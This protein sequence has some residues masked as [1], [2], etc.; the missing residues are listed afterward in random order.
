M[1]GQP[2]SNP[3]LPTG[4]EPLRKASRPLHPD[5]ARARARPDTPMDFLH[6][7]QR[8]VGSSLD[9]DRALESSAGD[10]VPPESAE[11]PRAIMP[12]EME[13]VA[14]V[15]TKG[16]P[17]TPSPPF[18]YTAPSDTKQARE[19]GWVWEGK[20]TRR[21]DE[22]SEERETPAFT[23]LPFNR[24]SFHL[25]PRD[26]TV[27]FRPLHHPRLLLPLESIDHDTTGA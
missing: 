21:V 26:H 10:Q 19:S 14:A 9:C 16:R 5:G 15:T 25:A 17:G 27:R 18:W 6:T 4:S 3:A 24:S 20:V 23:Y 2:A 11:H 7:M 13:E 12:A 1:E 22:E 8:R